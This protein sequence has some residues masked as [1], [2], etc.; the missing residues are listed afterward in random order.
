MLWAPHHS[1]KSNEYVQHIFRGMNKHC[2][3]GNSWKCFVSLFNSN[4]LQK[5]KN[6]GQTSLREINTLGWEAA[7]KNNFASWEQ[8]PFPKWLRLYGRKQVIYVVSL[9]R[10]L[11]KVSILSKNILCKLSLNYFH[12][13]LLSLAQ[14]LPESSSGPLS[15]LWHTV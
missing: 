15:A 10:S 11:P 14:H 12:S 6:T 4:W 1:G 13:P 7:V 5:W 9:G 8:T 3:K 2:W